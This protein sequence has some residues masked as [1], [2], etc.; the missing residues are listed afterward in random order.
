MCTYP[1]RLLLA[2]HLVQVAQPF[3]RLSRVVVL[4]EFPVIP[5]QVPQP[6]LQSTLVLRRPLVA[7]LLHLE[8]R[9][10]L[11]QLYRAIKDK[12]G[13]QHGNHRELLEGSPNYVRECSLLH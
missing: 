2:I 8:V 7:L 1:G 5:L 9:H 10:I 4:L 13:R 12:N 6:M 11:L 3:G